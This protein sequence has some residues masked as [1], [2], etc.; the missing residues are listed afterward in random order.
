MKQLLAALW[1]LLPIWSFGQGTQVIYG[2]VRDNLT[3]KPIKNVSIELL[4]YLPLKVAI[5]D[6][7]GEFELEDVPLGKHRLLVTHDNYELVIVPDVSVTAGKQV[8]LNIGMEELVVSMQEVVVQTTT[9]KTTRDQPNNNMA[10]MGI[11]SFNIEDVRRYSGARNDPSRLAANFAGVHI[12]NDIENGIIVRGNSHLNVLWQLEGMPIPNPNHFSLAGLVS[13]LWPMINT[14]LMRNSDFLNGAFPAQYGNVTGAVFDVGLRS[15]NTNIYEGTIQFGYTGLEAGFEGPISK[16]KGSSFVFSYRY[17]IYDIFRVLG[18]NIGTSLIPNN[19]D[20]S[21]KVDFGNTKLG[22]FSIFGLGGTGFFDLAPDDLDSNDVANQ[23]ARIIQVRKELGVLGMKYRLFLTPE[24]KSY[25]QTTLGGSIEREYYN[26]DTL[27]TEGVRN[28]VLTNNL[29]NTNV[30]LSSFVNFGFNFNHTLRV[31][32]VETFMYT[33]SFLQDQLFNQGFRD[34]NGGTLLSQ[35]YGQYLVRFSK[36]LRM[37]I[38]V[39]AQHFLL[40]NTIGV[41]PRFAL[42]WQPLSSHRFSLGY[43]WHHQTQPLMLYF[44]QA[45]DDNGVLQPVNRNLGFTQAHHFIGSYDWA[46]LDNWRLKAEGYYQLYTNVP[47]TTY[48]STFSGI[49][50]GQELELL[51]LTD[52]VNE[53]FARNFGAELTIEKFFSQ[54]YYGLFTLSYMDSKF[55]GSDGVWRFTPYNRSFVLNFLFGKT[56]KIGPK[57]NNF[58]TLDANFIYATGPRSTPV[59]LE[60]SRRFGFEIRQ[61][62][63]AYSVQGKDYLRADLRIGAQFNNAKRNISHMIFLDMIN[64]TNLFGRVNKLQPLYNSATQTVEEADQLGF[65]P[66][67][68]YRLTFGFKPRGSR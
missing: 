36:K 60:Q 32:V 61:W 49:N 4:N 16:N 10:I 39:N 28:T 23:F 35:V 51:Y 57:R 8:K 40:N 43:G 6:E 37:N 13:S 24:K 58:L 41:G 15:G 47:I 29:E 50:M 33:N 55:Q 1:L 65:F 12:G 19:Q 14:N 54:E 38:G 46:I 21:F 45:P 64:I 27:T 34:Y 67:L 56:F 52:L 62:D 68:T 59:D 9:K 17:S 66:D 63:F 5:T 22:N 20:L 48:S 30:I 44:N 25:W 11:R 2:E 3:Q 53:G 42:S 18:L 26:E 31:G 7:N